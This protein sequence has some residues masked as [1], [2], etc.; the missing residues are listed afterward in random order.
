MEQ[1]TFPDDY[2]S[3]ERSILKA[4]SFADNVKLL[5]SMSLRSQ[6][7]AGDYDGFEKVHASSVN[8]LVSRFKAIIRGLQKRRDCYIGDIKSGSVEDWRVLRPTIRVENDSVVDYDYAESLAKL[9]DL[10]KQKLVTPK[11][12]KESLGVLKP[13]LTPPEYTRAIDVLKFHIVRWSPSEVLAGRTTLRDGSSMT[14]ADAFHSPTIT[15]LDVVG[16]VQN[17][18][19]T[20]FSV[21]YQFIV[22]KTTLN[23]VP[24]GL[25][26][27]ERGLRESVVAYMEA[28][29]Y[30]KVFKRLFSLARIHRDVK[31]MDMF[32]PILNGDLGRLY[33]VIGDIDTLLYLLE[34]GKGLPDD[35]VRF[36]IDQFI[37]RLANVSLPA[38]VAQS[39]KVN[40]A[41]RRIQ[42]LSLPRMKAPL[43]KLKETLSEALQKATK[44]L[45]FSLVKKAE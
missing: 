40:K 20:D 45:L 32:T 12:F 8:Q 37:H 34:K 41:I 15:K 23:P 39:D 5:G 24:M 2:S 10:K 43:E 35:A 30:F 9:K 19:F 26:M 17:N 16:F 42:K 4:M 33:Y 44:P 6:Q 28:G 18:R 21:I 27:I 22:G 25:D 13:H 29:N 36:E 14:L 38:F 7:Y 11:E 3:D 31:T 1:K